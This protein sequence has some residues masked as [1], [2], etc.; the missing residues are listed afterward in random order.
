MDTDSHGCATEA[1]EGSEVLVINAER[2]MV[3]PVGLVGRN[4]DVDLVD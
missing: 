1:N 3:G 4:A 2:G